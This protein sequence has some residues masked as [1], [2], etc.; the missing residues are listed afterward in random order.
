MNECLCCSHP[1]LRCIRQQ[2]VYWFC[3]HCRQEMPNIACVMATQKRKLS[4]P[5]SS[6]YSTK[7]LS[8][9]AY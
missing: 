9:L 2:G 7:D 5:L 4:A 1:L 8:E 6:S 3:S